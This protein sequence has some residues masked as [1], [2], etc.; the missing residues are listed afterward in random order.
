MTPEVSKLVGDMQGLLNG[1]DRIEIDINDPQV[2]GIIGLLKKARIRVELSQ[3]NIIIDFPQGNSTTLVIR[4][5]TAGQKVGPVAQPKAP[6]D[7]RAKKVPTAT[8]TLKR[9]Q[10]SYVVP[11]ISKDMISVITDDASHVV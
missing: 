7:E 5:I 2:I 6:S 8:P 4:R 11:A 10:H 3:E 1:S 9:H